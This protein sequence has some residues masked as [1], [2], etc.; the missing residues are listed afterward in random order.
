MRRLT[1]ALLAGWWAAG[2][3]DQP[4][5]LPVG[6]PARTPPAP[7]TPDEQRLVLGKWRRETRAWVEFLEF[8]ADGTAEWLEQFGDHPPER[9]VVRSG[10]GDRPLT[11]RFRGGTTIELLFDGK[12]LTEFRE[13]RVTGDTLET[14]W[15][16]AGQTW[17]RVK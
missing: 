7:L 17:T 5:P 12:E 14:A 15:G 6:P 13:V 3:Q 10:L 11:Y 1:L 9:K 16:A 4:A 2:C 8:R